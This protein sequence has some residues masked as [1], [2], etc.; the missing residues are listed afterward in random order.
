MPDMTIRTSPS[1]PESERLLVESF[2]ESIGFA[3][4]STPSP[5]ARNKF[6]SIGLDK[7]EDKNIITAPEGK[8][9]EM[10]IASPNEPGLYITAEVVSGSI[11][12][13]IYS[14]SI[15]SKRLIASLVPIQDIAI[16]SENYERPVEYSSGI[17]LCGTRDVAK[18]LVEVSSFVES[19]PETAKKSR[20][21]TLLKPTI[22]RL[23]EAV[24]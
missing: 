23:L 5:K 10:F 12:Y 4:P 13:K 11:N 8:K 3:P 15:T 14:D 16:L 1:F 18:L 9:L 20:W 6:W 2:V 21:R 19:N 24:K 17:P 22:D 7:G